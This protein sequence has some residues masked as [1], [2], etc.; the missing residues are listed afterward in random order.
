MNKVKE[1]DSV[2]ENGD[3]SRVIHSQYMAASDEEQ[4]AL[5]LKE[6]HIFA[7]ALPITLLFPTLP[8][9]MGSQGCE[10]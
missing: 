5:S 1:G 4:K 9:P 3:A 10:E 6:V 7:L 2:A 8:A